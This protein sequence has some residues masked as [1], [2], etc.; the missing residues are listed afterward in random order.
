M[1]KLQP[2]MRRPIRRDRGDAFLPDPATG[3]YISL[4]PDAEEYIA[5]VTAGDSILEEARNELSIDE[6]V[7]SA[8]LFEPSDGSDS[9]E[10]LDLFERPD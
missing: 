6:L 5:S 1:T 3:V 4:L 8:M 7:S 10:D 2:T 9:D